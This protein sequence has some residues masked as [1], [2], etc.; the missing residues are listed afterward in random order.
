MR[1][2][3]IHKE[4]SENLMGKNTEKKF[5]E[6]KDLA[7]WIIILILFIIGSFTVYYGSIEDVATHIGFAGTIVSILLAFIAII[8]SFYQSST[9]ENVNHKLD[10]SANKIEEATTKLSNVSEVERVLEEFKT[11]VK[12]MKGGISGLELIVQTIHNGVDSMNQ[13]WE[14]TIKELLQHEKP[15]NKI[16]FGENID[17]DK[18]YFSKVI[19]NGGNLPFFVLELI[20]TA[21]ILNIKEIA[22]NEWYMFYST[23]YLP[24]STKNNPDLR[25]FIQ[26][27]MI[28]YIRSFIQIGF[29]DGEQVSD[30]HREV[31]TVN[32][33]QNN[34][35]ITLRE[36]LA[37]MKEDSLSDY[38]I[39]MQMKEL[40]KK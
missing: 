40:L 27:S 14:S 36:K 25:A 33:V 28:T 1:K 7:Y 5:P 2:N 21:Y 3:Y 12:E 22:I 15:T 35:S 17:F 6:K 11:E 23:N 4:R 34:L 39:Y 19:E 38:N 16:K 37:N 30:K 32:S 18:E 8:Y 26:A 9:Y 24:P 10:T 31:V 29:I 13:N 20:N